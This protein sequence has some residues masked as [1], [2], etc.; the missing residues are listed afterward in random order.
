MSIKVYNDFFENDHSQEIYNFIINS[1]YK[2]G[3]VDSDEPQ[4]R[5]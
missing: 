1:Y 5:A 4:H 2:I 3:W